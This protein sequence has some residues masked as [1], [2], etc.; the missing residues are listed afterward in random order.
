MSSDPRTGLNVE[1][2]TKVGRSE[3]EPSAKSLPARVPSV[4]CRKPANKRR[5]QTVHNA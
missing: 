5:A 4:S 3:K 2:R 1:R